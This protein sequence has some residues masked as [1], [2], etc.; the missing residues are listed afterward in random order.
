M[1]GSPID[2]ERLGALLDGRLTGRER[3]EL[4]A[5]VAASDEGMEV[6][7]DALAVT[8]ELEG[9][10]RRAAEAAAD[11]RVL[12]FRSPVRRP[13]WRPGPR[14]ALAASL[15]AVAVGVAAWGIGRRGAVSDDPGRYAALLARPG[16]PAGWDAA[17]WTAA[18]AAGEALAPR[19][20]AVRVGARIT[21][22]ET[23][24]AAR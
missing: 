20:R 17:P 2:P 13:A 10:D 6:F 21:D 12:P 24:A 19:A 3:A 22:L 18:R 1:N 14:L 15:A 11:P 16:L 4:L 5:R 9:E 8:D 7:A 23:A